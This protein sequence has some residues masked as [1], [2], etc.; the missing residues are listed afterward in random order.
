MKRRDRTKQAQL[1][2]GADKEQRLDSTGDLYGLQSVRRESCV[3]GDTSQHEGANLVTIVEGERVIRPTLMGEHAVGPLD[4]ALRETNR[5]GE[6][7]RGRAVPLWK[8]AGSCRDGEEFIEFGNR[9]P[10]IEAIRDDAK[11]ERLGLGYGLLSGCAVCH[12]AWQVRALGNPPPGLFTSDF[13]SH[14]DRLQ[15]QLHT[16]PGRISNRMDRHKRHGSSTCKQRVIPRSV[17]TMKRKGFLRKPVFLFVI[18]L[19]GC[20]LLGYDTY[21]RD[22]CCNSPS[23]L[24]TEVSPH[25]PEFIELY[26]PTGE[27]IDLGEHWC[28]YYPSERTSWE[29]PW[30]QKQFPD[31]AHI[32][33]GGHYLIS[34]GDAVPGRTD[35]QMYSGK[36][37]NAESGAVAILDG[38]T[39]R[40]VIID[41]VGWGDCGLFMGVLAL[42]I[43]PGLALARR[44]GDTCNAPFVCKGCN[45]ADFAL[46]PP[47]PS[48][49]A[50]GAIVVADSLWEDDLEQAQAEVVVCNAGTTRVT[51]SLTIQSDI[52][53]RAVAEPSDVTLECGESTRFLIREAEYAV[54]SLDLET[55]QRDERRAEIIEIAWASFRRGELVQ[56]Y[57]SL[58]HL[59]GSLDPWITDLTGITRDMLEPAPSLRDVLPSVLDTLKGQPVLCYSQNR[60]DQRLLE[61]AAT[62]LGLAFPDIL[63]INALPWAR[64]LLPKLEDHG[65]ATVCG[66]LEIE[67]PHHRALPDA[68][69][70]AQVFLKAL[71]ELGGTFTLAVVP[72]GS[73]NPVATVVLPVDVGLLRCE[74]KS[75]SVPDAY[76]GRP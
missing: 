30:R 2:Q 66:V 44:P 57:S 15:D 55:S 69:M 7:R 6:E 22:V 16:M 35:W 26:N 18:V 63:W 32:E 61:A 72:K 60:F 24:I 47:S 41:A 13:D 3:L 52:G 50:F 65:L 53:L 54:F 67:G 27:Q 28:C 20:A 23:I 14:V 19:S 75:I 17:D 33:A 40:G 70:T 71:Q 9:F 1:S 64:R 74:E 36:M 76:G 25:D 38:P 48:C 29:E 31:G 43:P 21:S 49:K 42:S 58:V 45:G 68:L 34:L 4:L 59:R 12:D 10:M 5:S 11:R 51:Y 73:A 62:S 39:G 46:A 8:A 37:L 56:T